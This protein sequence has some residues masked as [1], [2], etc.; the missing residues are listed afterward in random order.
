MDHVTM[1][2]EVVSFDDMFGVKV[3]T[4]KHEVFGLLPLVNLQM[5]ES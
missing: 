3:L 4:L 5:Y 2:P 1:E